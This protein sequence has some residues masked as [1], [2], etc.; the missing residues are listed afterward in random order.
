MGHDRPAAFGAGAGLGT[1]V[2]VGVGL[3]NGASPFLLDSPIEV[4]AGG[5]GHRRDDGR[6]RLGGSLE[7]DEPDED[8]CG[9]AGRYVGEETSAPTGPER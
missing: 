2:R 7:F 6:L 5:R 8:P 9:L 1:A 4:N 3:D